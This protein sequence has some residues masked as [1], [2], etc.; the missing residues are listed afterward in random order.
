MRADGEV[1]CLDNWHSRSDLVTWDRLESEPRNE[2]SQMVL[3]RTPITIIDLFAGPGGLGEG[4][5]SLKVR[6]DIRPFQIGLSIEKDRAAHSTLQLR[7]FFRQFHRDDVPEDYYRLLRGEITRHELF[8]RHVEQAKAA[9]NEA[10]LATLGEVN[11]SDLDQRVRDV[12]S[13][14]RAWVLIG[15]PPCQAYSLVGRS[16]RG[17]ISSD[18]HRVF[19]YREYLRILA[20]H[21]PPVFVMENVKGL[22]SSKLGKE[23]IFQRILEDLSAPTESLL[24]DASLRNPRNRHKVRY[25]LYSL[26]REPRSHD[27]NGSPPYE[28][29]DFVIRSERFG[30]PQSRHRVII[31]GVR[32]D[33]AAEAPRPLNQEE[34]VTVENVLKGLPRLRSGLSKESDT[35]DSW[36]KRV[37]EVIDSGH[38]RSWRDA[39]LLSVQKK[40]TEVVETLRPS[41][42]DRGS[43][44]IPTAPSIGYP[45]GRE[46]FLD[47]RIGGVCNHASRGHIAG[48]L[49]R[50][51]FAACFAQVQGRSPD[52]ADFP[53]HLL[54]AHRNVS[55]TGKASDFAD[56]FRVQL[57]G[58]PATTVTS[59]I[60]KDGHYYIHY[61]PSQ[62]RSLTVREAARLQTFPDN[63][64]FCGN[65]TE[66]YGQVGNAV[67]PLLACKI[68][69]RIYEL[70]Q[71]TSLLG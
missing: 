11:V 53:S 39:E 42:A 35:R 48:D 59:H 13:N 63:Y 23:S 17:G 41:R 4:F 19:L 25:K 3:S 32:E 52:L 36:M 7:A 34:S 15:G 61:D 8:S 20:Q 14:E 37:R 29:I 27:L 28:P 2:S 16:R 43:E 10:W 30:V 46:W 57:A 71:R 62:C 44:F 55:L 26:A 69:S 58:R 1:C 67:P 47:P 6:N 31:V 5:S 24:N 60:A 45:G 12:V 54:P 68:A 56:R 33:L 51:I 21:A 66:Q 65:R 64:F 22:L 38:S 50:Y 18:D 40:L 70:L 49:H 9:V